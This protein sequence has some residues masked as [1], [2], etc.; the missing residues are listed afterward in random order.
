MRDLAK[1]AGLS[2]LVLAILGWGAGKTTIAGPFSDPISGFRAQDE[3]MY[4]SSALDLVAHDGWLTPR[5]LGRYLLVKPPLLI[6]L[7]G[8]SLKMMGQSSLALR[9]PVLLAAVFATV[10][11]I[12]WS[13]SRH[14]RWIAFLTGF[15]LVANPLW[16]IL[17]R[18][19]YTDM[20]LVA[21]M[22]AA[23][24]TLLRDPALA[25]RK[26]LW[27]F[28]AAICAGVM[29]KN[30]AGLL[31]LLILLLSSLPAVPGQRPKIA[32]LVQLAGA[33]ALLAAPWHLYQLAVHPQWFWTDYVQIQLLQFGLKP[34]AQTSAEG[35][36]WF[37][38]RRLFLMDPLLCV[39]ALAAVPALVRDLRQ[40][41]TEAI[42][43]LCWLLV[44]AAALLA[45]R[46]R[47]LPYLVY[48]I[49]P[50]ALI[51]A[52][53]SPLASIR[54]RA[55]F[56]GLLA[57]VFCVKIAMAEQPWGLAYGTERPI[58]SAAALR[59]YAEQGRPNELIAVA[60]DDEFYA[61]VLPL[62]RV[63]YCYVDPDGVVRRY[64]PHYAD[65]GITLSVAEFN[66][67]DRRMAQFRDRLRAWGLDSAAPIGT[68]IAARST[69]E[70][71]EMIEKHPHSDFYLPGDMRAQVERLA[72]GKRRIEQTS[73]GRFFLLDATSA[74]DFPRRHL[75]EP[76]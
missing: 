32:R 48:A 60:P 61:A 19:C 38:A 9:L 54:Y 12:F 53:Y 2:I 74:G 59:H 76:W 50:L 7:A 45:F 23:L 17:S 10:L 58:P 35:P 5:V 3:T 20:L 4:A 67:L 18:V 46:Y 43:L 24:F 51:A 66:D 21:A 72:G 11:L 33:I 55:L 49:A 25:G 73:T 6:W 75:P 57:A 1:W 26:S 64:A 70:V 13:R 37:Y 39:L 27:I 15:L 56:A 8:F 65:L 34:P 62:P 40:R 14:S 47:N 44:C 68:T 30:V 42:L 22:G 71:M 16:H 29:A 69:A 41:K 63:R 28:A 52:I 31:P 36:V